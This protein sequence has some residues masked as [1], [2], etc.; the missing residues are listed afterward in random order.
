MDVLIFAATHH[1]YRL[2]RELDSDSRS[3]IRT[4]V[5]SCWLVEIFAPTSHSTKSTFESVE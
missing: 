2:C 3:G 5:D 1:R 4:Y